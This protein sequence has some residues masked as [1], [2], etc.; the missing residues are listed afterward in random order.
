MNDNLSLSATIGT[1]LGSLFTGI[2]LIALFSQLRS[3]LGSSSSRQENFISRAAGVWSQCL[4]KQAIQAET[5]TFEQAAPT[6][7][8][9][10][11][12]KYLRGESTKLILS[13]SGVAGTSSWSKL[14]AQCSISPFELTNFGGPEASVLPG[15]SDDPRAPPQADV[16]IEEG[17]LYY[18]FSSTEFA[19]F[20][21]LCG[22]SSDAF[23]ATGTSSSIGYLGCMHLADHGPFAQIAHFDPHSGI[24]LV[25][26]ESERLVHSVP[27]RDVVHVALGIIHLSP[28]RGKREW[29]VVPDVGVEKLKPYD[30][31]RILPR[32]TQL[33]S[34]R[35]NLEQLVSVS[36]GN[37][38]AY[39]SNSSSILG[40]EE[41]NM[42]M[43]I[44]EDKGQQHQEALLAAYAIDSLNPW[45]LLPIA[46]LY[47]VEAF[48]EILKP[49]VG[50]R[51]ETI[52]VLAVWLQKLS[53]RIE[54]RASTG[55]WKSAE[56]QIQALSRIGDIKTEF[57]CQSSDY[58]ASYYHAMVSVFEC[59]DLPLEQV[60]KM[61]ATT[62]AWQMLR[63]DSSTHEDFRDEKEERD[64]SSFN[65]YMMTHL[66]EGRPTL[67]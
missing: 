33:S 22:L 14:F 5:G 18:G 19:S 57:F 64:R 10:I 35:Y 2:G 30:A 13:D 62:V 20:L 7:A 44:G 41:A 17:K 42:K 25:E 28:R 38:T 36:V 60:K 66:D 12:K 39:S 50:S 51:E 61:L 40:Q 29:I 47:L 59:I 4:N 45:D 67:Y 55:G 48:S 43:L 46:P 37:L 3:I 34:L 26:T 58:C 21:I 63:P 32:A 23:K 49:C 6:L 27:I 56:E 16:R 1:W 9:W 24:N 52:G 8:G 31:W 54:R 15:R 11:Q 65:G 53:P